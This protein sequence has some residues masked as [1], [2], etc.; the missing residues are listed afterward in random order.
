MFATIKL[1]ILLR[2]LS[3]LC[4]D[5]IFIL[6]FKCSKKKNSLLQLFLLESSPFYVWSD[7]CR[8]R[9]YVLFISL[10]IFYFKNILISI[11]HLTFTKQMFGR[12]FRFCLFG[13]ETLIFKSDNNRMVGIII[14]NRL[15]TWLC[16]SSIMLSL[17]I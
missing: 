12:V 9:T 14:I 8:R 1:C 5:E 16:A 13:R 4:T 10:N 2:Y 17:L 7:V 11:K 6:L 15:N 3:G